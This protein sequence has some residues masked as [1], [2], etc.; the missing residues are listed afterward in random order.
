MYYKNEAPAEGEDHLLLTI[1]RVKYAQRYE[2][3]NDAHP[4]TVSTELEIFAHRLADAGAQG[5]GRELSELLLLIVG[6][7]RSLDEVKKQVTKLESA[8]NL[9]NDQRTALEDRLDAINEALDQ[10]LEYVEV[11]LVQLKRKQQPK[12]PRAAKRRA[13]PRRK[14]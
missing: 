4:T 2:E 3:P 9:L 8:F 1:T 7:G 12:T 6:G 11:S 14:A 5:G 10:R 13:Q